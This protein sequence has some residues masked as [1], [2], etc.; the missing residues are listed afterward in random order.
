MVS[1]SDPLVLQPKDLK[2]VLLILQSSLDYLILDLR[3]NLKV[4]SNDVEEM[5]VETI[6]Q[7]YKLEGKMR[8]IIKLKLM[9]IMNHISSSQRH[10]ESVVNKP[11]ETTLMNI[12]QL[13]NIPILM[14]LEEDKSKL[15]KGE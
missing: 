15:M 10:K 7:I 14:G 6:V 1:R 5:Q 8:E 9:R 4:E 13:I 2:K 12:N 3:K 11:E